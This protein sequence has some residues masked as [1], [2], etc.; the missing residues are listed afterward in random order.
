MVGPLEGELLQP[1]EG[2]T[3]KPLEAYAG[4]PSVEDFSGRKFFCR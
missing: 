2:E 3:R 4:N 1:V